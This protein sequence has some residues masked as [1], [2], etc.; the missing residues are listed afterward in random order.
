[1]NILQD[2]ETP[3]AEAAFYLQADCCT[4]LLIDNE[5]EKEET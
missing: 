3:E 5:V 4:P 1:M 2:F